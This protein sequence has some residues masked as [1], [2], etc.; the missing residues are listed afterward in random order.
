MF[1]LLPSSSG[2]ATSTCPPSMFCAG[3]PGMFLRKFIIDFWKVAIIADSVSCRLGTSV[4]GVVGL[5]RDGV[6]FLF[7][8]LK[9]TCGGEAITVYEMEIR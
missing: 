9:S 8:L 1:S 6:F 5:S 4:V 2:M 3:A 7:F